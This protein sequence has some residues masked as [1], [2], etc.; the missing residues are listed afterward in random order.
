MSKDPTVK[1]TAIKSC[2]RFRPFL[3][4]KWGVAVDKRICDTCGAHGL[5]NDLLGRP[6]SGFASA[7]AFI[8][9]LP[10]QYRNPDEKDTASRCFAA[11]LTDVARVYFAAK[12]AATQAIDG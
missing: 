7:E 4:V 11:S 8:A 10:P 9:E 12:E 1:E 3:C 5:P 2:R 6:V